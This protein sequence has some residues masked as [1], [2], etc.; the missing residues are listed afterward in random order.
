M[1]GYVTFK[2]SNVCH[3]HYYFCHTLPL[4]ILTWLK[5]KLLQLLALSFFHCGTVNLKYSCVYSFLSACKL[6]GK[7]M[8]LN[9]MTTILRTWGVLLCAC[10]RICMYFIVVIELLWIFGYLVLWCRAEN[11]YKLQ[12]IYNKRLFWRNKIYI[13]SKN[14]FDFDINK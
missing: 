6:S 5:Q 10:V 2:A 7:K 12:H 11:K 8:F 1:F 9:I 4:G 14:I 13:I 3:S